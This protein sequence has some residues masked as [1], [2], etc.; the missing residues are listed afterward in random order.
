MLIEVKDV[1]E[2]QAIQCAVKRSKSDLIFCD[3]KHSE[4]V[5]ISDAGF[6]I[7]FNQIWVR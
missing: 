1:F 6:Q 5:A 2:E 3:K 7:T 4:M